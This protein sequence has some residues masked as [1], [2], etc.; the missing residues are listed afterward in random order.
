MRVLERALRRLEHSHRMCAHLCEQW[1]ASKIGSVIEVIMNS[2]SSSVSIQSE[3]C[4]LNHN[5]SSSSDTA[6]TTRASLFVRNSWYKP[7]HWKVVS[8]TYPRLDSTF[9]GYS[10]RNEICWAGISRFSSNVHSLGETL[11]TVDESSWVMRYTNCI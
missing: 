9:L 2:Q 1:L 8:H 4:Y 3:N 5:T 7:L 10:V 11:A 6:T